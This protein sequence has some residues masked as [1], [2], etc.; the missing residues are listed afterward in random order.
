MRTLLRPKITPL[1]RLKVILTSHG[2]DFGQFQSMP[3]LEQCLAIQ[4][5]QK[6][7]PGSF[8]SHQCVQ[9][10]MYQHAL[11]K[12]LDQFNFC[13]PAEVEKLSLDIK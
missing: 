3:S 8:P 7:I 11:F 10:S 4:M 12:Q 2:A 6:E 9:R 5:S 13:E 1:P